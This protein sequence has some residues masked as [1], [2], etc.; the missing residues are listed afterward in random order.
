MQK[1]LALE[2]ARAG[3]LVIV[4]QGEIIKKL[5]VHVDPSDTD[6]EVAKRACIDFVSIAV[7]LIEAAASFE[8]ETGRCVEA[9][10]DVN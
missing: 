4:A 8:R 10:Q 1:C 7:P 5:L 9:R 3:M 6:W 2:L